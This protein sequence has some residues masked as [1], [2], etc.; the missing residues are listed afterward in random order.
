MSYNVDTLQWWS[1]K[2]RK[3]LLPGRR[4][5]IFYPWHMD[6]YIRVNLILMT[7]MHRYKIS[8]NVDTLQWR[9]RKERQHLGQSNLWCRT[10]VGSAN[11][12]DSS[13]NYMLCY[14]IAQCCAFELVGVIPCLQGTP[15]WISLP[16]RNVRSVDD[17]RRWTD[18]PP[19]KA[20]T[21]INLQ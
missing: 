11:M 17:A 13:R 16:N 8:H 19:V 1:W 10:W 18:R 14:Q 20:I 15:S 7:N 2:E 12:H 21:K 9:P 3:N 5:K 6:I 4:G